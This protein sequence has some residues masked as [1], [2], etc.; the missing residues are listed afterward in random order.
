M[1]RTLSI[2]SICNYFVLLLCVLL[3]SSC[4]KDASILQLASQETIMYEGL[5]E[6]NEDSEAALIEGFSTSVVAWDDDDL[7][8]VNTSRQT[9]QAIGKFLKY[10]LDLDSSIP[11]YTYKVTFE[12]IQNQYNI[13]QNALDKRVAQPGAVDKNVAIIYAYVKRD[14]LQRLYIQQQKIA[15]SE[16]NIASNAN[17]QTVEEMKSIFNAVKPLLDLA[18]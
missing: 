17:R 11:Y 14:V 1:K 5:P 7:A 3:L 10:R 4:A 18:L 2:I 8:A 13:L 9:I 16:A 15:A 12:I 6:P